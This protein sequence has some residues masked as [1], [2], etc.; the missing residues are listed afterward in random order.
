MVPDALFTAGPGQRQI[1]IYLA[2]RTGATV[3][4]QPVGLS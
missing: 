4:F 2:S 1:Q 3:T